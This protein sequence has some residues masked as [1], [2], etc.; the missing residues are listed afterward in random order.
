MFW[1][2]FGGFALSLLVA[3]CAGVPDFASLGVSGDGGTNTVPVKAIV[4][5]IACELY[6]ADVANN[7]RLSANDYVAV[8]VMNL[9][10]EDT[11]SITPSLNFINN[12]N[13]TP[14]PATS[15]TYGVAAQATSARQRTFSQALAF[16]LRNI[17]R[18]HPKCP[19]D[20]LALTGIDLDG[21]LGLGGI[22]KMGLN[23]IPELHPI[24]P[25]A[26]Q[27]LELAAVHERP[28][29]WTIAPVGIGNMSAF[30]ADSAVDYPAFGSIIQFTLTRGVSGGPNWVLRN[31][32]GPAAI[33]TTGL[34]AYSRVNTHQL[35]IAFA[36]TTSPTDG[37]V[38]A[39]RGAIESAFEIIKNMQL[40]NI[41]FS[42]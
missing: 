20:A 27:T 21:D 15:L 16:N 7:S 18:L 34:A 14:P 11:A 26:P 38:A 42:Q 32:K 36:K 28:K 29:G 13:I 30:L 37:N 39:Q 24:N 10:V 1:N 19:D 5:H 41:Q 33:G 25:Q 40:N 12:F 23:S 8:V 4:E 9:K 3:G 35:I 31:F 22:A 17:V 6:D 2:R